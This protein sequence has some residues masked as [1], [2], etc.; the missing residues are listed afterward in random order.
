MTD[1]APTADLYFR[2][3]AFVDAPFGLDG[4]V[5]RVAGGLLWFSAFEVI[6]VEG[7]ERAEPRLVTVEA[8]DALLDTL[9]DKQAAAARETIARIEAPRAPLALGE[10]TLRFEAP[11]VAGI[12]NVTP[13][14]FSDGGQHDGDPQGAADAGFA[15]AADGAALIDVGGES[16]RPGAADVWEGDEI[17]RVVPVIE[18]LAKSGVAI[19]VDTRKA[20]VMEAALAA[21]AAIVNDVS[22]LRYDDRAIEVVV[23]AGCPVVIMHH[24][25]KGHELHADPNYAD[26]LIEVYDWLADRIAMLEAAGIARD[27]VIVDPGIGFGKG[28]QHNL[29]LINGLALFHGLGCPVMLGASRKRMIGALSN[30]APPE[31]RLGGSLALALEGAARGAQLLRVHD[32]AESVQALHVWRGLKDQALM[33]IV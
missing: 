30:E 3:A 21:G 4:K 7:G 16:T 13:D 6:A 19:S 9:T 25:G 24:A 33:P 14:S 20:V 1:I 28:L 15:M 26:P 22:A 11:L 18:R 32:V 12:L 29:A 17:E 10:R 31:K 2:P 5:K 27:R 23:K 8:L